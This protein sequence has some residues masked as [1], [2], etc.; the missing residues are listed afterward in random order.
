[1]PLVIMSAKFYMSLTLPT[2]LNGKEIK[3]DMYES[4]DNL[5][6]LDPQFQPKIFDDAFFFGLD[7]LFLQHLFP[8][9]Q[10]FANARRIKMVYD[11]NKVPPLEDSDSE[12]ET[13][14]P[15]AEI[16]SLIWKDQFEKQYVPAVREFVK[17]WVEERLKDLKGKTE[18]K[19]L[20]A[21]V[22]KVERYMTVEDDVTGFPSVMW[23]L[24][25]VGVP[26]VTPTFVNM[27]MRELNEVEE[28]AIAVRSDL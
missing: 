19:A 3:V 23:H 14:T 10:A 1:M 5:S 16:V 26:L 9:F 13:E 12:M 4:I 18:T 17:K 28:A 8:S 20:K 25:K 21:L 24:D 2:A 11:Q 15:Q 6:M 7:E 27:L 22:A